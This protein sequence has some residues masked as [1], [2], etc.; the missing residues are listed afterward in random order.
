M[1]TRVWSPLFFVVG[2]FAV[3]AVHGCGGAEVPTG[4]APGTAEAM[5]PTPEPT[6]APQPT[7]TPSP[8]PAPQPSP[9]PAPALGTGVVIN[10][11]TSRTQDGEACGE[12]VELRN[13]SSSAVDISGW[14]VMVHR[15]GFQSSGTVER[16]HTV[17]AGAILQSGCHYLVATDLY[18]AVPGSPSRD[19]RSSCGINDNSG[20]ALLRADGTTVDQ[21][22]MSPESIYREG[23]PLAAISNSAGHGSY[24]RTGADTDNNAADFTYRNPWSPQNS[25]SS[26]S[27]R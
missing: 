10:E 4:P 19:A 20:L 15:P 9:A 5:S 16:Y 12:F 27:I 2:L 23:S 7:P 25:T 6:P 18:A 13:D 17:A 26:C 3:F 8:T 24:A 22:G 21:V 11:F 1:A 14:Q